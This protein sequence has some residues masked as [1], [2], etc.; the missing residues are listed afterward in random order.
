ML[1]VLHNTRDQIRKNSHLYVE[2]DKLSENYLLDL[3]SSNARLLGVSQTKQSTVDGWFILLSERN[4]MKNNANNFSLAELFNKFCPLPEEGVNSIR[5]EAIVSAFSN[6][7]FVIDDDL[8]HIIKGDSPTQTVIDE[9][10]S[11]SCMKFI[12][13]IKDIGK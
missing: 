11:S 13:G 10:N 9:V 2:S 3:L 12:V 4:W 6:N 7:I 5:A 8:L 1:K